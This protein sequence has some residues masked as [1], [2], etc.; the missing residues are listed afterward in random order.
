VREDR[1][2]VLRTHVATLAVHGCRVVHAE[3]EFE[4][5]AVAD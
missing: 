5:L 3:E 2:P 4:E 1:G